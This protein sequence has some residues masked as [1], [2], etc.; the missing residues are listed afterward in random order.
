MVI[1][2]KKAAFEVQRKDSKKLDQDIRQ[3][4]YYLPNLKTTKT[5]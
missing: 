1:G 5:P 3:N 4:Y 2:D